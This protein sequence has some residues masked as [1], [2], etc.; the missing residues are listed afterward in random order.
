MNTVA[1]KPNE[2]QDVVHVLR[3]AAAYQPG[4]KRTK[5]WRLAMIANAIE[6]RAR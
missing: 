4:L 1:L 3:H 2:I 6:R 5:R